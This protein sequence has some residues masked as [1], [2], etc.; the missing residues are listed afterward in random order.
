VD[1]VSNVDRM[2]KGRAP[3]GYDGQPVNLHHLTQNEPGALAEVGGKFHADNTD[4]LHGMTG[5]GSSFRYSADGALTEAEKTF[6]RFKYWYWQ[7]RAKGF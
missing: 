7:Q 2:V 3:I 6:N 4:V 5:A 1:D